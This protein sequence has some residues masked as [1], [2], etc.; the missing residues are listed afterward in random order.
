ME[1]LL[2]SHEIAKWMEYKEKYCMIYDGFREF[3]E[4]YENMC[5]DIKIDEN[6]E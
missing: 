1:K 4:S 2:N 6:W 5:I 3:S